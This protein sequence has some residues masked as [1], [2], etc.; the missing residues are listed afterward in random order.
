MSKFPSMPPVIVTL[1]SLNVQKSTHQLSIRITSLYPTLCYAMLSRLPF[2]FSFSFSVGGRLSY[3][4]DR[5]LVAFSAQIFTSNF[6]FWNILGIQHKD[7][8]R[9]WYQIL[10]KKSKKNKKC[11]CKIIGVLEEFEFLITDFDSLFCVL[12]A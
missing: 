2:Y 4:A 9:N 6:K 7:F 10:E 3:H 11:L 1:L 12:K 8:I 5:W